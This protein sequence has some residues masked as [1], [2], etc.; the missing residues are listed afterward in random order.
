M[1]SAPTRALMLFVLCGCAAVAALSPTPSLN[2]F[3]AIVD[4]TT[5][6]AIKTSAFLREFANVSIN[7]V[8]ANG[9]ETWTGRYV[10]G[11]Q[12]YAE[13]F[14]SSDL[15]APEPTMVGA[16][17]IAV[18]GDVPGVFAAVEKRLREMAVPAA[19]TVR[20]RRFGD[21]DVN[22]FRLVEMAWPHENPADRALSIYTMEYVA[23]YFDEPEARK[24]PA[25]SPDDAI[26]RERY[27]D[28]LYRQ[29]AMRD[30]TALEAAVTRDDFS[31]MEPM[32]RAAGFDLSQ[33]DG[34]VEARGADVTLSFRFVRRESI[35][36]R[37]VDFVLNA[38]VGKARSE[39]I[40]N[41]TL[42]V[43]PGARARWMFR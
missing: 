23:A 6:G 27:L 31:R 39:L 9:G 29:H 37:R 12:T 17:G 41:S 33:S 5:A 10:R 24:E 7:T 34:R 40:G 8:T 22:W 43:G 3:Y 35:G 2:H 4:D 28:D 11:R 38:P 26:S 32:L 15:S 21:R 30:I 19:T 25:E 13:F 42:T 16:V 36:L 20:T 18:S 1:L 14:A